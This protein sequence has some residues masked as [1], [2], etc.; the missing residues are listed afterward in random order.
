MGRMRF[1]G[2]WVATM[3][4]PV[5]PMGR[6]RDGLGT[7]PLLQLRP[8]PAA[9]DVAHCDGDGLLLPN[10]ND[11]PLAAGDAGVEE[12]FAATWRSAAS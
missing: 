1:E 2:K 5:M 11:K 9:R 4:Q 3:T 12:G 7:Q 8:T 10:Q 6:E